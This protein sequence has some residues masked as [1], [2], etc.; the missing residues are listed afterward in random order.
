MEKR[1]PVGGRD[2]ISLMAGNPASGAYPSSRVQKGLA[3]AWEERDLS[4]EGVG[5]GVPVFRVGLETIFP[6][7]CRSWTREDGKFTALGVDYEMSLVG[8]MARKGKN[9]KI[10][11]RVRERL[12]SLHRKHPGL[13]GAFMSASQ[14]LRR[15]FFLEDV[16][17]K[18][19]SAGLVRA[20]Y[21]IEGCSIHVDLR[22]Q[23]KG[24][25]AQV[26]VM[27]EQ[28]ANYFDLYR[29]SDGLRLRG[30]EI[31]S[32]DETSAEE[33]SFVDSQHRI[34][35]TLEKVQGARMFRGREL[36]TERLAWAGLAYV[37]PGKAVNFTYTIRIGEL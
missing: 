35:F 28:G 13:R 11:H 33:A 27:N 2:R 24:G 16:F 22:I 7:G 19:P 12:S 23:Q 8:R 37:L 21:S 15:V 4:E 1:I 17:E 9:M 3:L 20:V 10:A 29:D 36:A 18:I 14:A 26:I 5:F 6:G 30:N 31:G 34:A 25:Q 32:W